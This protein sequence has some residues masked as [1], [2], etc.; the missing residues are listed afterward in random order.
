LLALT[1]R[2][3]VEVLL[4][5]FAHGSDGF[6]QWLPS[7]YTQVAKMVF[8]HVLVDAIKKKIPSLTYMYVFFS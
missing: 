2:F 1:I 4:P 5:A 7:S 8:T 6:M 3:N